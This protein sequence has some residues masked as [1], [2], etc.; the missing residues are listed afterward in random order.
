GRARARE[1]GPE[2]RG[3]KAAAGEAVGAARADGKVLRAISV[4]GA[5]GEEGAGLSGEPGVGGGR[6]A[7]VRGGDGP[8]RLG[9]GAAGEP[10]GGVEGG[11]A[12]GRGADPEGAAGGLLRPVSIEDHLPDPGS[13]RAGARVRRAGAERG[14]EAEVPE[15]AG[16]R[17]L[18]EEQH[19]LRDRPG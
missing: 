1:R 3:E 14:L 10:A 15:L 12:A 4:G 13:A 7:A 5:E 8:E 6:A 16:G 17:A 18:P 19:A 11:W 9:S 2:G